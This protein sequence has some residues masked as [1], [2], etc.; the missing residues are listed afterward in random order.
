[1]FDWEV[2]LQ[3]YLDSEFR[4]RI[5]SSLNDKWKAC[6]G[7]SDFA[8]RKGSIASLW[9]DVIQTSKWMVQTTAYS[10]VVWEETR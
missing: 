6:K 10:G 3:V 5:S 2:I 8:K 7:F 9:M 4:Q 1:M